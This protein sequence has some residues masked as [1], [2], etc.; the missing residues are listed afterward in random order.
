[1]AS[2][3]KSDKTM[4]AA[5]SLWEMTIVHSFVTHIYSGTASSTMMT[6]HDNE[7]DIV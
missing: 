6:V 7:Q 5:L 2:T 1:M 4:S 3:K